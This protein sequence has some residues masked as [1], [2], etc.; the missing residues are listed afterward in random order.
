MVSTCSGAHWGE[1]SHLAVSTAAA[2]KD[3]AASGCPLGCLCKVSHLCHPLQIISI[4]T[5]VIDLQQHRSLNHS[6]HGESLSSWLMR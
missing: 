3:V 4:R 5:Q 1:C 6:P 2:S